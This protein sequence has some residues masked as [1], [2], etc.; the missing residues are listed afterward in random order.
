MIAQAAAYTALS[1]APQSEVARHMGRGTSP[2]DGVG[3]LTL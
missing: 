1:D 2:G 3:P